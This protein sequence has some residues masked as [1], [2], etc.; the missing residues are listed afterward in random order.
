M[1]DQMTTRQ[2]NRKPPVIF[3]TI[4]I[5][6][7]TLQN[8][9]HHNLRLNRSRKQLYNNPDEIRLEEV[10]Q[11]PGELDAGVYKCRVIFSGDLT[12]IGFFKYSPRP[13]RRI[14]MVECD[15]IDYC[16]KYL[17][18]S[19]IDDLFRK[20]GDADDILIIRNG[21]ITD[22]SY[23]NIVFWNGRYW[24]TPS[25]PLLN[26]TARQR[27][28]QEGKIHHAK[29]TPKDISNFL[30]FKLINAMLDIDDRANQFISAGNIQ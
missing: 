15:H 11:V 17:D 26:G 19:A 27:L 6:N 12:T 5:E 22:T 24:I 13:V 14:K 8:I 10:I 21:Y 25:T 7:R 2:D 1:E 29:L 18:R 30:G 16:H 4:K 9:E 23:A 28:L 20:R 3:E